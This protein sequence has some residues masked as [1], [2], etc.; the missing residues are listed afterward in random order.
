MGAAKYMATKLELAI[1]KMMVAVSDRSE[2]ERIDHNNAER[3]IEAAERAEKERIRAQWGSDKPLGEVGEELDGIEISQRIRARSRTILRRETDFEVPFFDDEDDGNHERS[4]F[5][6]MRQ[7]KAMFE[8][9]RLEL[10]KMQQS[11]AG[12]GS[13]LFLRMLQIDQ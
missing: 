11:A 13:S 1:N 8:R 2:R 6:V 12:V 3:E 9:Q 7:Q 5:D 4:Y 10:S